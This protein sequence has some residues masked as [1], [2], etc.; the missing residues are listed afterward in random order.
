LLFFI[1][2]DSFLLT[3][4]SLFF[5][6]NALSEWGYLEVKGTFYF[7][8]LIAVEKRDRGGREERQIKFKTQNDTDG[9][10]ICNILHEYASI[11]INER[12]GHYGG[13]ANFLNKK[14]KQRSSAIRL[15]FLEEAI[16]PPESVLYARS[17][18]PPSPPPPYPIKDD[19][20]SLQEQQDEQQPASIAP[21]LTGDEIFNGGAAPLFDIPMPG[22]DNGIDD[23]VDEEEEEEEDVDSDEGYEE[24]D[25]HHL[26]EG[27]IQ[28]QEKAA[29]ILQ[30]SYR[31]FAMREEIFNLDARL[32][33]EEEEEEK[34]KELAKQELK[35]RAARA[36][37]MRVERE[38]M[39]VERERT[40]LIVV[41]KKS[42]V[43]IQAFARGYKVRRELEL[44]NEHLSILAI[45]SAYRQHY[46]SSARR[47]NRPKAARKSQ[48]SF[49]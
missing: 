2:I 30:A 44:L 11:H 16:S 36:K 41:H 9:I 8:E 4:L 31:G 14:M 22:D 25:D 47:H 15:A 32:Q 48:T 42:I 3:H 26:Y 13:D 29:V 6:Y 45:Q 17:P 1:T 46:A 28:E 49:P 5:F 39:R 19:W 12:G 7:V 35:I 18:P 33:S 38:R 37:A 10:E 23:T 27:I 20:K 34:R 40:H 24:H 21:H 43:R